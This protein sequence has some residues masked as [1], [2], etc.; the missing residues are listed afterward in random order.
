MLDVNC[1]NADGLTPLLLVTR[2]LNL[3]EKSKIIIKYLE[4]TYAD[5]CNVPGKIAQKVKVLIK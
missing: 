4:L 1:T 2:D 5:F 3:F